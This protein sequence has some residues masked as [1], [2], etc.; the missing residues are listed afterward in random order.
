[1]KRMHLILMLLLLGTSAFVYAQETADSVK[2]TLTTTSGCEIGIDGNMSSTNFMSVTVPVGE[3]EVIVK[4]GSAF[5]K[6]FPLVV[7]PTGNHKYSFPIDGKLN[8]N[9]TPQGADVFVDGLKQGVTPF[10]MDII[11]VH[12]LRIVKDRKMWYTESE[13]VDILPMEEKRLD[14]TLRKLPLKLS[15]FVNYNYNF[16]HG[17]SSVML[18]VC[19]RWGWYLRTTF[20]NAS[21]IP[22]NS[23]KYMSVGDKAHNRKIL[24]YEEISLL[25]TGLMLRIAPWL[26]TYAGAGYGYYN[27]TSSSSKD[28]LFHNKSDA[29]FGVEGMVVD[30][31]LIACWKCFSLSAGYQSI[32]GSKAAPKEARFGDVYVGL[33]FTF[34]SNRNSR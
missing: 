5:T 16:E 32:I 25:S 14:Y 18:G 26:Y 3:H 9:S 10:T 2:I 12:S 30:A 7:E 4:Y 19:R 24:D 29:V 15:W 34:S 11:G 23:Y 21:V 13:R 27:L 1:M 6:T 28:F 31:G 17:A 22:N 33:G 20:K 8:I